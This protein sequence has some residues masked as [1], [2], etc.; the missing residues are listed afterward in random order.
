MGVELELGVEPRWALELELVLARAAALALES[1]QVV[2]ARESR[3]APP[4]VPGCLELVS[5]W[6]F[7][8]AAA[9]AVWA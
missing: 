7:A 4:S 5:L 3:S 6:V 2:V 8:S 1:A 9:D